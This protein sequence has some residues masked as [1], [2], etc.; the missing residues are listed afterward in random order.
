MIKDTATIL[1]TTTVRL[2]WLVALIMIGLIA[3]GIYM[4]EQEA[5]ALY[6]WHKSLGV[7]ILL[8]VVPRVIWRIMNGWPKAVGQ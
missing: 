4:E 3:V 2:H 7:L 5:Y 8:L 1:S 6:P